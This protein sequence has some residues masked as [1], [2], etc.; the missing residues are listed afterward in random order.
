MIHIFSFAFFLA[1]VHL[2]LSAT[3]SLFPSSFV[4]PFASISRLLSVFFVDFS[5]IAYM[6]YFATSK[7]F[8]DSRMEYQTNRRRLNEF[9]SRIHK[10]DFHSLQSS[11]AMFSSIYYYRKFLPNNFK[12]LIF[13]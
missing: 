10:R 12:L 9:F 8:G 13:D 11:F 2:S 4:S 6:H 7:S 5:K 1:R 3:S